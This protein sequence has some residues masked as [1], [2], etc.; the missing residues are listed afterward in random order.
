MGFRERVVAAFLTGALCWMPVMQPL[1]AYAAQSIGDDGAAALAEQQTAENASGGVR[2]ESV[3]ASAEEAVAEEPEHPT[4]S[5]ATV[6]QGSSEDAAVA[7]EQSTDSEAQDTASSAGASVPDE[8]LPAESGAAN[9][10]E[11]DAVAA[12]EQGVGVAQGAGLE[13]SWRFENGIFRA[14]VSA[15]VSLYSESIGTETSDSLPLGVSVSQHN[16]VIDWAAVK[17]AGVD[18]AILRLGWGDTGVDGQFA[19]NVKGCQEN[20][21]PFGVWVYAYAWDAATAKDEAEGT[22]KR[23][24]A[25]GVDAE[26]LSLPVYYDFENVDPETGE[27]SG[28]DDQNT[29][30]VIEGGAATF[31]AMAKTFASVLEAKGYAVGIYAEASWWEQYLTDAAFDAWDRWV[32]EPSVSSCSIDDADTWE[33]TEAGAVSGISS[34]AALPLSYWVGKEVPWETESAGTAS[35]EYC[36]HV[37]DI[38][39]QG[40]V[41]N[42]K[43]AGTT[44]KNKAMEALDVKLAASGIAGSVEVNAHVQDIG[45]Q[46]WRSSEKTGTASAGTTGQSKQME[47]VE[48]RLTGELA[49]RY[50]VYYRAHCAEV[51]WL[52]WAKNGEP[53]GTQG[54]GYSLQALKIELVEK[55]GDPSGEASG[56]AFVSD[57]IAVSYS[58]HVSDIG[59]M[60]AVKNGATAGTTGKS[61]SIEALT[62]NLSNLLPDQDGTVQMQAHVQDVGWPKDDAW[63]TGTVGTTGQARHIEAVRIKLAG[64]LAE[65]Y[66]IYYR[67]H[68]ANVGW[69]AWA[70]NGADAGTQGYGYGVEAIQIRLVK[71]GESA[72]SAEGSVTSDAFR[73]K[74]V[75]VSYQAHVSNIG[76]QGSVAGGQTAGTT[77]R[78]LAVEALRV[79]LTNQVLS[80]S[81]QM[82]AHVSDLGWDANWKTGSVGT[83]GQARSIQAIQMKLTGEMADAYDIY[84]R[85]HSSGYGWLDW[86]KNGA[87]AGTTGLSCP[88]EAVQIKL[89]KKGGGAPGS[90][91]T[92]YIDAPTITYKGY[93]ANVAWGNAVTNGA[94]AG[95]TGRSL[96][97]EAFSV[98]Y[99]SDAVTGGVSY[100]AHVQDIG[101]QGAVS[102]GATAGTTGKAKQIEAIQ[103]SLTGNAANRYDIW[104]RVYVEDFG[105]LGWAKNGAT[106]GTTSC[107]LRVEAFQVAVRAKGVSA[108]G[109]TS[110][111]SYSSKQSLPYIG[112]QNPNPYP[113]VSNKTVKLPSY[114]TGEFTYVSPSTIPYNATRNDCI[115]AFITRA[116]DY[117]GTQYIEPY[118]T[119]PGGA[120]D[121]SGLVLQCLYATGMDMG[122][123]NPYNHR[124]LPSQTYNSMNWYRNNTFKPVSTSSLQRGDVVYYNGHIAIYLGNNQII[125]SWPRQGVSVRS[126]SSRGA[127]IGAARPYVG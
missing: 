105:W 106:A 60:G 115:N 90:T 125:D 79:S 8:G 16:G 35:L 111:A 84:Y 46:G 15:G 52:G 31:A 23:L 26:D 17:K 4:A 29:Y 110:G 12:G 54:H 123:Y 24:A 62:V 122:W 67:V 114:C 49:D 2:S 103:I 100:R 117:L 66:D 75:D 94:T 101:W 112:F 6:S 119:A 39:W 89:V 83:T 56:K 20:G 107:G 10:A 36:A 97:L 124:W 77:G 38:G 104:Y 53:A 127:V 41:G 21:I 92:P 58:A 19:A 93:S 25:A 109:S 82:K 11:G 126:L 78:S 32:A 3:G 33:Y 70:K 55:G 43:E 5:A 116:F 88:V 121:C 22:V 64:A 74:P 68:A 86:A 14:D 51:G 118:S 102:N 108:P 120:V 28:R 98:T 7:G 72:P 37:A 69:M 65:Q 50:D 73:R 96:R 44:G 87:T 40:F 27:P 85:V 42:G 48:I 13:N 1:S 81:V 9:T 59:W 61:K 113:K 47:A 76:W 30:R 57:G 63:S 99:S 45:W 80:G 95:T 34:G 18:F 71:K 91:A